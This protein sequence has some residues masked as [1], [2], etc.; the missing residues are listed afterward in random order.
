MLLDQLLHYCHKNFNLPLNDQVAAIMSVLLFGAGTDFSLFVISRYREELQRMSK[1]N[2]W[3]AMRVTMEN[4]G[5]AIATSAG[6]TIVA[7]LVLLFATNGSFV[8]VGPML[9]MAVFVMLIVG[10]TVIPGVVVLLGK[11]AFWPINPFEST[12]KDS[13]F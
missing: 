12:Q 4:V 7:M 13:K 9:A 5:P 2:K 6:T 11:V 3:E 1:V 8:S 10:L